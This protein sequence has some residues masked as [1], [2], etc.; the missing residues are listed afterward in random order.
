MALYRTPKGRWSGSQSQAATDTREEGSAPGSYETVEVAFPIT[1]QGVIDLL[2][3]YG[4]PE[5]PLSVETPAEAPE[6]QPVYVPPQRGPEWPPSVC[7]DQEAQR[8]RVYCR[9]LF[10]ASTRASSPDEARENIAAE[11]VARQVTAQ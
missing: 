8:Y 1:R 11:L 6:A 7:R 4:G 10:V 9:R 5:R 2:N 3:R